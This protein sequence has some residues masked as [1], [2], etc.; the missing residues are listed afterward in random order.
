MSLKTLTLSPRFRDELA[1]LSEVGLYDDEEAFL[2][3]AVRT[4]LSARPDLREA[5]ACKLY[6]RGVFSL[7]RAAEWS[8]LP[9][10]TLKESLRRRGIA[11]SAFESPAETEAMARETLRATGRSTA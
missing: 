11:R 8:D 10:E 2:T 9:I 4:F 5:I 7:S 6:E 3:D 1:A